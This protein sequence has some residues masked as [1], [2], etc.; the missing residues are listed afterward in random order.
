MWLGVVG[1]VWCDRAGCSAKQLLVLGELHIL[2][3]LQ[4]QAS[5]VAACRDRHNVCLAPPPPRVQRT[6]CPTNASVRT[7]LIWDLIN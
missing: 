2:M 6:L 5:H 3:Q 7:V 4:F 1:A